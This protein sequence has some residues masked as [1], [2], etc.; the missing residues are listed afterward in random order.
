MGATT[1]GGAKRTVYT[2]VQSAALS[3]TLKPTAL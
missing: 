2:Q 1:L 3:T